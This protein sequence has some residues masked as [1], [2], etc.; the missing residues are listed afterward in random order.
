M[1]SLL[2]KRAIFNDFSDNSLADN[3]LTYCFDFIDAT[4]S[5]H[6]KKVITQP[7]NVSR[8]TGTGTMALLL[9]YDSPLT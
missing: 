8:Y 3:F 1:G 9:Y 7:L 4:Y 2:K 6:V 5:Q